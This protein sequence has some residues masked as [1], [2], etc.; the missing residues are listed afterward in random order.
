MKPQPDQLLKDVSWEQ[1][2][3]GVE[4]IADAVVILDATSNCHLIFYGIP[5][6]G[7]LLCWMLSYLIPHVLNDFH[8]ENTVAITI[9]PTLIKFCGKVG[10]YLAAKKAM[11]NLCIGHLFYVVDDIIDSG[12][13]MKGCIEEAAAVNVY[14][15]QHYQI[16]TMFERYTSS[17]NADFVPYPINHDDWLVFP[18]E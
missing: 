15:Q 8:E 13:T 9:C 4:Q 16:I 11:P 7:A 18:Y 14:H 2:K 10:G 5:R 1:Y 6:G 3:K 17:I 12:N